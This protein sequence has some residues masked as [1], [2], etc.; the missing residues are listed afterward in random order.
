MSCL[1]KLFVIALGS[2][3]G[4]NFKG[5]INCVF[6]IWEKKHNVKVIFH[7]YELFYLL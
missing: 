2:Q 3:T 5:E 4:L 6:D 7:V 1:T